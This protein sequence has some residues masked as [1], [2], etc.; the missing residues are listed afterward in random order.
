ML[1]ETIRCEGGEALHLPY[2]QKRLEKSS[3]VLG[4]HQKYDLQTLIAPPDQELYRCRFLYDANGY[5]IE[6]HPYTP[7]KIASLKLLICDTIEYPLK[8]S[9][10]EQLTA[11]FEQREDCDDVLIVKNN[12]LTDTTIANIALFIEGQWLTPESPLLEGTTRERLLDE[13]FLA[14]APLRSEDIGRASKIALMN[15]MVGF[16]EVENGIII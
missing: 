9:E 14:L 7:K 2:H 13:K 15:A 10:R 11:L 6:Y 16:I 1:L 8:Y 3:Q 5:T 12:H 4:I